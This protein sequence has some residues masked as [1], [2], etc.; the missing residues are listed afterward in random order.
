MGIGNIG[1]TIAGF[2]AIGLSFLFLKLLDKY[3]E[4]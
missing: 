4:K 3:F 2:G 1:G